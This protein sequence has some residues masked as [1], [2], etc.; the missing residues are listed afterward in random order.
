M[1]AAASVDSFGF[2]LLQLGEAERSAREK[3]LGAGEAGSL[4][5]A[6]SSSADIVDAFAANPTSPLPK[7]LKQ[8]VRAGVPP[9]QRST[10]WFKLSGGW[11]LQKAAGYS[12]YEAI[13]KEADLAA[14]PKSV[15]SRADLE[16]FN[17]FPQHP[18]LSGMKGMRATRRVVLAHAAHVGGAEYAQG[19]SSVAA[20]LLAVMG[21]G[22]EEEV[23][24]TL[25]A[26]TRHRLH[27]AFFEELRGCRAE[28]R[29]LEDL[30]RR[31][32]PRVSALFEKL[33]APLGEVTNEWMVYLFTR[34]LPAETT[35]R[36]FDCVLAEG[37]KALHRA[38][39]ALLK[40]HEPSLVSTGKGS[41]KLGQVFK[42]RV[43]RTF[44]AELL[45]KVAYKSM[46][47]LQSSTIAA[48]RAPHEAAIAA[49]QVALASRLS[50]F[51]RGGPALGSGRARS[52]SGSTGSLSSL[53]AADGAPGATPAGAVEAASAASGKMLISGMRPVLAPQAPAPYQPR[54]L[55]SPPELLQVA[56][57]RLLLAGASAR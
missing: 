31:K 44:D 52:P 16:L 21:M 42:W 30:A 53:T 9:S 41:L 57:L 40:L 6:W 23:F 51:V 48:L 4:A 1:S 36:V 18:L 22:Q 8:L 54:A 19:V 33:E 43:A 14:S 15:I 39:L 47:T 11:A 50:A 7:R 34:S 2:P 13:V 28:Q 27:P 46:G 17:P 55:G 29:T 25:V 20:F 38:G 3:S 26:L 56:S 49:D 45:M 35:A 24:W 32:V 12:Y 5:K 10:L 37:A